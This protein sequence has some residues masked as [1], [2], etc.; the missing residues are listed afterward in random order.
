MSLRFHGKENGILDP[1]SIQCKKEL[2]RMFQAE[3]LD[4]MDTR[5]HRNAA[6]SRDR[7]K[8]RLGGKLVLKTRTAVGRKGYRA[9]LEKKR[10]HE[11]LTG[12][13]LR[14]DLR[15]TKGEECRVNEEESEADSA[16][17]RELGSVSI[18]G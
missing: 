6:I 14:R 18:G 13:W 10:V 8:P 9:R 3:N 15:R 1:S 2:K 4:W 7:V 5:K 12:C 16:M 11:Q 17:A